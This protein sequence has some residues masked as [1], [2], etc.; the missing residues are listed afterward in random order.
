MGREG[1]QIPLRIHSPSQVSSIRAECLELTRTLASHHAPAGRSARVLSAGTRS[2]GTRRESL[3]TVDSHPS[4]D[5]VD[6][7]GRRPEAI[8]VLVWEDEDEDR[9]VRDLSEAEDTD[10]LCRLL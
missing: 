6:Q 7:V 5:F 1:R 2:A 4:L 10:Q 8:V 9:H 3:A